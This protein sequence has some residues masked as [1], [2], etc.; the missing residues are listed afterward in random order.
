MFAALR[1]VGMAREKTPTHVL[2]AQK[3]SLFKRVFDTEDGR[4]VLAEMKDFAC[5]EKSTVMTSPQTRMLDPFASIYNEGKRSLM[6]QCMK[7][8]GLTYRDI[9]RVRS[10]AEMEAD[11]DAEYAIYGEQNG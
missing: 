11:R 10:I 9:E 7:L 1:G 6:L 3:V 4:A 2:L 8:S 5:L